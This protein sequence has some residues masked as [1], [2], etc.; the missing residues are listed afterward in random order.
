M[1]MKPLNKFTNN[2]FQKA[3]HFIRQHIIKE[4]FYFYANGK[5]HRLY[6]GGLIGNFPVFKEVIL[7]DCYGAYRD[8]KL[9]AHPR[10]IVD[11]GAH[12]GMFS[13]LCSVLFPDASIVSY[14]PNPAAFELLKKNSSGT[15]IVL[16]PYAVS[17]T[18]GPIRLDI[19]TVPTRVAACSGGTLT[20]ESITP[21]D[22]CRDSRID[23]LK[24]DCEGSEWDI[25]RD[26]TLLRRTRELRME[27]HLIKSHTLEDLRKLI[28]KGG[29]R[30]QRTTPSPD[31]NNTGI[32][33][34][35][36]ILIN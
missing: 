18:P 36:N 7:Q 22:I 35:S 25:L 20:V 1:A 16:F 23:I 9:K 17:A 26:L 2:L 33:W 24:I 6:V 28:I 3:N 4:P 12:A 34:S 10:L 21:S 19:S 27:Y 32:L 5:I 11:I 31:N 14:E 30:I 8:F 29:H 15:N 13:K